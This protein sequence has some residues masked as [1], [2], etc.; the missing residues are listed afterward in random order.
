[1][2]EKNF[3]YGDTIYIVT[4]YEDGEVEDVT[5]YMFLAECGHAVIVTSFINDFS[6][7]EI[8][9]YHIEET[10]KDYDTHMAVFPAKDCYST[11]ENAECA[12]KADP[13]YFEVY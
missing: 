1:M 2:Q 5:G 9:D 4:R 13:T 3:N 7:D 8:L 10:A 12:F 6:P 11:R